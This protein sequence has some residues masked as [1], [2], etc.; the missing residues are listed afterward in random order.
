V[1]PYGLWLIYAAKLIREL[2]G[3]V[4]CIIRMVILFQTS[5]TDSTWNATKFGSLTMLEGSTYLMAACLPLYRPFVVAAGKRI[6]GTFGS[7][8]TG[9]SF[10]RASE[11]E[12]DLE[13]A[14]IKSPAFNGLGFE[15]LHEDKTKITTEHRSLDSDSTESGSRRKRT[16][17][18]IQVKKEYIVE[19]NWGR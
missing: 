19:N 7:K 12:H 4:I 2:S 11:K 10:S 16:E 15:R 3:I 8:F 13:L 14:A 17:S 9:N 5:A 18:G 6:G 1:H